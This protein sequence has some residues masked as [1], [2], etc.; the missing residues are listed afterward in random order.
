MLHVVP[1]LSFQSNKSKLLTMQCHYEKRRCTHRL[2]LSL[3]IEVTFSIQWGIVHICW[4]LVT[5]YSIHPT[6][7]ISM[8]NNHLSLHIGETR[9]TLKKSTP[10]SSVIL[11]VEGKACWF[12]PR[13]YQNCIGCVQLY[14]LID[15][16]ESS[17]IFNL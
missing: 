2:T 3:S 8:I 13:M 16:D 11:G 14:F 1:H 10:R 4:L 17:D 6:W 7:M 15:W 5:L 12:L 9:Q